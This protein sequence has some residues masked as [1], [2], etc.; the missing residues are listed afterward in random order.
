MEDNNKKALDQARSI[1]TEL[2][3]QYKQGN[4][5]WKQYLEIIQ[6]YGITFIS[7]NAEDYIFYLG[8]RHYTFYVMP[9]AINQK[10]YYTIQKIE[11]IAM[12]VYRLNK[13]TG[14]NTYSLIELI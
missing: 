2:M 9:K 3:E 13:G 14:L 8:K 7:H 4:R 11:D 5:D 12:M 6:K 1:Y 10:D